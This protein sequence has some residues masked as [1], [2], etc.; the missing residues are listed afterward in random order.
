[1]VS[2]GSIL[3]HLVDFVRRQMPAIAIWSAV[4]AVF[5]VATSLAMRPMMR[6]QLAMAT[7]PPGTPPALPPGFFTTFAALYVGM[8]LFFI[9]LFAAVYRAVFRPEDSQAAYLRLGGD[10]ARLFGLMLILIIGFYVALLLLGIS[11][12]IIVAVLGTVLGSQSAAAIMLIAALGIALTLFFV[13]ASIRIS[14]AAPLTILRRKLVIREGWRLS[15]GHFWSLFGAFL[16]VG[17]GLAIVWIIVFA[18]IAWPTFST[19]LHGPPDPVAVRAAALAQAEMVGSP[20]WM[21]GVVLGSVIGG[22]TFALQAGVIAIG[23]RDLLTA[24]G[25]A[26]DQPSAAR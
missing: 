3:S 26:G 4:Y 8:I 6:A 10:E 11:F 1:M 21:A 12:G 5:G 22:L 13:W 14:L 9:V 7:Q 19:F 24:R 25:E 2:T 16:V 23:A 17:L 15:K 20:I 18:M